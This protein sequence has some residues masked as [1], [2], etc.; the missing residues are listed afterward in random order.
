MN[1]IK[2][3]RDILLRLTL[4][5]WVILILII[6][7]LAL[8]IIFITRLIFGMNLTQLNGTMNGNNKFIN[9][10]TGVPEKVLS[11]MDY[12]LELKFKARL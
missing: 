5:I 12:I 3:I 11:I 4:P 9:L 10:I 2:F 7:V 8:P 6:G 1:K